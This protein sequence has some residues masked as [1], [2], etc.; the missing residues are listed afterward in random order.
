ML[1]YLDKDKS[2]SSHRV[3]D[4]RS[5]Q[6]LGQIAPEVVWVFD[7]HRQPHESFRDARLGPSFGSELDVRS[8][9][10]QR[11][12]RIHPAQARRMPDEAE[13]VDH[14]FGRGG[15]ALDVEAQHGT[16]AE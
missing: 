2:M 16:E 9:S 4:L 12:Q 3:R 14:G 7:S 6:R 8:V 5:S 10:G 15:A 1:R 13:G 11:R